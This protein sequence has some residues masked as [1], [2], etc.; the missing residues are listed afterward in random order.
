MCKAS[1]SRQEIIDFLGAD[2]D[3]VLSLIRDQLHSDV[4]LL[5]ETNSRI[6]SNSGKMLRPMMALL[7]ATTTWPTR[8]WSGAAVPR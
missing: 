2:W 5:A 3:R 7:I 1:V 4:G 8:V 6:L